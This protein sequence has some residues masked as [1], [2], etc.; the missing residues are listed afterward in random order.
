MADGIYSEEDYI[1][2]HG[3]YYT[4]CSLYQNILQI[5]KLNNKYKGMQ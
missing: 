4:L 5:E 3:D 1:Y 2:F